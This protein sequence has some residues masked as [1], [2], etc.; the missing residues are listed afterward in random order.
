MQ[1]VTDSHCNQ[2]HMQPTALQPQGACR[3]WRRHGMRQEKGGLCI[4]VRGIDCPTTER[5][6]TCLRCQQPLPGAR[7]PAHAKPWRQPRSYTKETRGDW[8][9]E[10]PPQKRCS[11]AACCTPD[12]N[13]RSAY[14]PLPPH[15]NVRAQRGQ[16]VLPC[17]APPALRRRR[18]VVW[19]M[20]QARSKVTDA[21][22]SAAAAASG[23][24]AA[25]AA[26]TTVLA[27]AAAPTACCTLACCALRVGCGGEA[28]LEGECPRLASKWPCDCLFTIASRLVHC[29][30]L[31]MEN[32]TTRQAGVNARRLSAALATCCRCMITCC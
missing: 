2:Q 16:C 5:R 7:S 10:V 18:G 26:A 23:T 22:A 12:V 31:G 25:A 9:I 11:Y 28:A 30:P 24:C 27:A 1:P 14:A 6:R 20:G 13:V 8:K 15:A 17:G 32:P 3:T 29:R 19:Q 21:W 4:E